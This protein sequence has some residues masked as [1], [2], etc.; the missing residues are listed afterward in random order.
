MSS[1]STKSAPG[2]G[3]QSCD[4]DWLKLGSLQKWVAQKSMLSRNVGDIS[5]G[6]LSRDPSTLQ[7][8]ELWG[9]K[10]AKAGARGTDS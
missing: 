8:C 9:R 6:D 4:R 5:M 10:E 7:N 3:V 1:G 2:S